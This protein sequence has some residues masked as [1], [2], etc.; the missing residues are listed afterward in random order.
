MLVARHTLRVGILVA[1][2]LDGELECSMF[3]CRSSDYQLRDWAGG[4]IA[5]LDRHDTPPGHNKI[6]P[7]ETRRYWAKIE[8]RG[9]QDYWGEY[10]DEIEILEYWRAK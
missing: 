4:L 10:D 9:Y 7:G 3:H 2:D 5:E 6:K 8:L 1:A